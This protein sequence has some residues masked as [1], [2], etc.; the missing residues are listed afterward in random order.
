MGSFSSVTLILL[1]IFIYRPKHEAEGFD[2]VTFQGS[3]LFYIK[4][5]ISS[6]NVM[7]MKVTWPYKLNLT[8]S[9]FHVQGIKH[10][11]KSKL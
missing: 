6:F 11:L 4:N 10:S 8:I 9:Y 1:L 5:C 3:F 2:S 7:F